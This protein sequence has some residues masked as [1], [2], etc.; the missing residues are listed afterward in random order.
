MLLVHLIKLRM[1]PL[2]LI[3]HVRKQNYLLVRVFFQF[4]NLL[5]Q[6]FSMLVQM[7]EFEAVIKIVRHHRLQPEGY[8]LKYK[9]AELVVLLLPISQPLHRLMQSHV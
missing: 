7:F 6:E 2:P 4:R 8:M 9:L 1:E 3:P 5:L